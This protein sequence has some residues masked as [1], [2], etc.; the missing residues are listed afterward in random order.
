MSILKNAVDSIALGV[1]DFDNPDPKRLMSA[2]RNFQ[3]GVLLLLKHKLAEMSKGDD[4]ALIKQKVLPVLK[5]TGVAW[6][7]KGQKTVDMQQIE[8]RLDSLGIQVDW[9]PIKQVTNYRNDIEHYH[10][11]ANPAVVRQHVTDCFV[12]VQEFIKT[13]LE[14]DPREVLGMPTWDRLVKEQAVYDAE[15]EACANQLNDLVWPNKAA[16]R[17]MEAAFCETCDSD[18]IRPVSP[19][20]SAA[21]G[22]QFECAVCG[23]RTTLED[24]LQRAGWSRESQRSIRDGDGPVVGQCPECGDEGY[25]VA[26]EVCVLCSARGPHRCKRCGN[27][28]PVEE[29]NWNNGKMCGFCEHM[30]SKDD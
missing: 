25:D 21:E 26:D 24:F 10:T 5:G 13:H 12:V 19:V 29:L 16:R 14:E 7:G 22:N 30:S 11:K 17:W 9:G 4:E 15:K 3:A 8:D 28:I 2:V 1:E 18:L 23:A 27:E 6:R 20:E